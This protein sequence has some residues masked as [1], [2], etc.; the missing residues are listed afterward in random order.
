MVSFFFLANIFGPTPFLVTSNAYFGSDCQN[1][2]N[3]TILTDLKCKIMYHC[4]VIILTSNSKNF[5]AIFTRSNIY[6]SCGFFPNLLVPLVLSNHENRYVLK[7]HLSDSSWHRSRG[8]VDHSIEKRGMHICI[9][10]HCLDATD[11]KLSQLI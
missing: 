3:F 5:K 8:F 6:W 1:C 7:V 11:L 10:L 9:V 4:T 2:A